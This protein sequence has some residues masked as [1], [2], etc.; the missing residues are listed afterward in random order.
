MISI[1]APRGGSDNIGDIATSGSDAI[2]IHAPRGGSDNIGDIAT[3]GSDAI[4]IHAPRGGS[5]PLRNQPL[6]NPLYFNPRS[7]WGERLKSSR[8]TVLTLGFQSTLPVGGATF[9]KL[10]VNGS[11]LV[12]QSTLPVGGATGGQSLHTQHIRYFNPRSPWGERPPILPETVSRTA[13]QSTL[14]V[15]GATCQSRRPFFQ[16]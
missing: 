2:S 13:F 1:H 14:P 12:F 4:S 9:T 3:S 5:D 11:E 15:G 10:P 6:R 16:G 7:P 8:E